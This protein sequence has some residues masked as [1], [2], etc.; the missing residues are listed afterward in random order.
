MSLKS[1]IQLII[2]LLIIIILGGVY[3]NYFVNNEKISIEISETKIEEEKDHN[4]S[5]L[6]KKKKSSK[7]LNIITEKNDAEVVDA[8]V[9][10]T[11]LIK[12][13]KEK[14]DMIEEPKKTKPK[15]DNIVKEIEYITTDE[16]G[17]KYKIL[18]SSGRTNSKNKNVLDLD[19]V[20]GIIT[21]NERST[22]NIISDFAEYNSLNLKSNF[23]QNVV[24]NYEDKEIT[25]DY[26]DIDMKTNIAIAYNNVVVTDSKSVMK[27]GKIILNIETKK[28]NINPD[29]KKNKVKITIN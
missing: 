27:A 14:V 16:K 6:E 17:N 18:A 7:K 20:K 22:V 28:I 23:Y 15:I 1:I 2:I 19:N 12:L 5:E 10:N 8:E 11:E 26:F 29:N 9:I 21:S 13:D 3:F 4:L 24:I 25:C